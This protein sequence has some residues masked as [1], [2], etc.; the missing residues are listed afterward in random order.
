MFIQLNLEQT[1]DRSYLTLVQ[2]L[3]SKWTDA[4]ISEPNSW[5]DVSINSFLDNTVDTVC[6]AHGLVYSWLD[7]NIKSGLFFALHNKTSNSFHMEKNA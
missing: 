3:C 1:R 2:S 4:V 6:F 5:H 7:S